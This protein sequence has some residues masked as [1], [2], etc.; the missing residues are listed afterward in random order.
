MSKTQHI[1]NLAYG[2][3]CLSI[4]WVLARHGVL[5]ILL[6]H[7]M[8]HP[9]IRLG[10]GVSGLWPRPLRHGRDGQKISSALQ[11]L[12]PS[13]IKLGQLLATRRDLVGDAIAT[14]L[15][16]LQD[17][18]PAFSFAEVLAIIAED[19]GTPMDEV[20][21]EFDPQPVAAASIAQVHRAVRRDGKLCAVKVVRPGIEE[22]FARDLAWMEWLAGQA[23][24]RM[25]A[26]R[27][28]RLPKVV[29]TLGQSIRFEM[30]LRF[31]AAAASEVA[32]N[33]RQDAGIRVPSIH[34]QHT[35]RRVM[36]MEWIEGRPLS[37]ITADDLT[38][39]V[40]HALVRDLLNNFFNMVF[41]DGFFH[42]DLHPGNLFLDD[43]NRL[44]LV[45]FGI[46]GRL[47]MR[48][49]IYLA[50]LIAGFLRRDYHY[51]AEMHHLAGYI[52][53]NQDVAAFAQACRSIAEPIMDL[54][55]EQISVG[56]LLTQL[57]SITDMFHMETQTQLLLLQK[58]MVL[59]EGMARRIYP[60]TNMWQLSE[61]PIRAW[62]ERHLSVTGR[63]K[64]RAQ[65]A[66]RLLRRLPANA[67]RF[68]RVLH[69]LESL[70]EQWASTLDAQRQ[71]RKWWR[72]LA[73]GLMLGLL[74][75]GSLW[76]FGLQPQGLRV[77][78]AVPL[79]EPIESGGK[80]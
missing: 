80:L 22:R 73:V 14:D 35:A 60:A 40:A 24:Q 61:P 78:M 57:F 68:E 11:A 3:R 19:L 67:E 44:V 34:W 56:R 53:E 8:R 39:E 49:R 16:D 50:E 27:R 51:V 9:L 30:D 42:A 65:E 74:T 48:N 32:E 71:G 77:R 25:P 29:E 59:V 72:A 64:L 13:F 54:P 38:P 76:W 20:F 62:M 43:E 46:M 45:D 18:L 37:S 75:G 7:G 17:R 23:H 63:M 36:C 41:R 47:D 31:E 26:L 1:A 10:H 79:L 70:P 58:S 21:A 6:R 5:G 28:L 12:G 66:E 52:P 33:I 2:W 69:H 15:S 55:L 4:G